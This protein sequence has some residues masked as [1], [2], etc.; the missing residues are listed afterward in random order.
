MTCCRKVILDMNREHYGMY[1][2][3]TTKNHAPDDTTTRLSYQLSKRS[4]FCSAFL[5]P[6]TLPE[7][8]DF[9]THIILKLPEHGWSVAQLEKDF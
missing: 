8:G 1:R 9:D 6:L 7:L 4:P 2:V 5:I 3:G